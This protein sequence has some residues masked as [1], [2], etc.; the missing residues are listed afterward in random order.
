[1]TGQE[2]IIRS[3]TQHH[4][5]REVRRTDNRGG[6]GTSIWREAPSTKNQQ[7][8]YGQEERHDFPLVLDVAVRKCECSTLKYHE[9][10]SSHKFQPAK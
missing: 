4:Y 7:A 2:N 10:E 6:C 5:Q 8:E 9:Q 1:M 3:R